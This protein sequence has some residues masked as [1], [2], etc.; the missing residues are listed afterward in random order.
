MMKAVKLQRKNLYMMM[1]Q[2]QLSLMM[3]EPLH[4]MRISLNPEKTW[5]L[6]GCHRLKK[7]EQIDKFYLSI[8][9]ENK[10]DSL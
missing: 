3:T 6:H 9:S 5:Y 10:I 4:G 7:S 8:S 2:E 1:E